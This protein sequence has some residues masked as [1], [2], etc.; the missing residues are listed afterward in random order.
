MV[1]IDEADQALGKRASGS[2]DSGVSS[3]VYS[4]IAKEMSNPRNRGKL[5]WILAS[6]RPDLIEV[7]LKR[8]GRVDVKIP[9]F[10]ATEAEEA[11]ALMRSL[12]GKRG[13][14]LTDEEWEKLKKHLPELLTAGGAEALAVKAVR[15]VK[16]KTHEPFAAMEHIL[17]TSLPPVPF[18]TLK[19]QMRLAVKEATESEFVP[20]QIHDILEL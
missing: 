10:P 1:F 5:V 6:S 13:I 9:I 12:S 7:D 4:M 19:A 17:T 15:L 11:L 16:T 18:E 14:K 8:P 20:N 2:G 3:R